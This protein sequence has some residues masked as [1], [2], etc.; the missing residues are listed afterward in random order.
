M[1]VKFV[2]TYPPRKCGVGDHAKHLAEALKKNGIVPEIIPIENPNSGNPFYFF[3]L[4]KKTAKGMSEEDII[5]IQFQLTIF[6]KLFK[7]LP[8]FY[9]ALFLICLKLLTNAK[10]VIAMH[11]AP[12]I[13]DAREQGK[14]GMLLYNYYKLLNVF[15]RKFSDKI[16][17]HSENAKEIYLNEWKYPKEKIVVLPLGLPVNIRVLNKNLAKKKIGY[18]NK[19]VLAVLGYI[20]ASRN[21]NQIL[22]SLKDLDKNVILIFIGQVQLKKHQIV[23]DNLVKKINEFGLNE[24]VKLL[25]FVENSKMSE[26]LSA[27]DIGIVPYSRGFGDFMSSTMAMQLAYKIP[28]LGTNIR[29]FENLKKQSKCIET[30][31][32]DSVKD[33]IKK[34]NELLKD[35]E[36]INSL[37]I[38]TNKYWK[39]NNWNEIG[40][41]TKEVYLS[42]K[43]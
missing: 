32:K 38:N 8:G 18:S 26:Y 31:D 10:I 19:K 16:I 20:K 22:E 34:I 21:Y 12:T 36:K 5:H 4:A 28:I 27:T 13:I 6:G 39:E 43:D 42:L 11:D 2:S 17:V 3:R 7:F 24:R 40:R 14:K 35:K 25:G 29:P 37:K 1:K 15:T 33:L 41:K 30:Y 23:Y 9:M